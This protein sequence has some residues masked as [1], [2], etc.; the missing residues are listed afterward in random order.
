MRHTPL[1]GKGDV[2]KNSM[3]LK[4]VSAAILSALTLSAAAAAGAGK[5]PSTPSAASAQFLVQAS[6]AAVARKDVASVG[7]S[8]LQ[9]LGIV[10]AVAAR[11]NPWQVDRL[12]ALPGV[13]VFQDRALGMR[14]GLL[15]SLTSTLSSVT[16]T[17]SSTVTNVVSTTVVTANKV[18]LVSAVTTPVVAATSGSSTPQDGTGENTPTLLYQT[19]YPMLVGADTLQ[20]AGITGRRVTIAVLDSGLWQSV[21]QNYGGR[22]LA[23][24]DVT[25]GGSGPVTGDAYGHGTHITSIAA[26][27]AVNLSGNYLSI[28]PQ[29][30]LVVVRA[31]NGEGAGRYID[32]ISGLNWI[33]ANRAKYNIRVLNLSFGAPPESNYWND[34]LNQAVMAAWQAGIVVVVA[35]GNEGPAPMTIDVPGNVPY[36]ITTGALTDNYTP[37]NPADDRLA[38]FS[39]AGPT[40]E[41]FVK[42]EV[43]S[44][45][46]HMVASMSSQSYLANIDPGSMAATA[47]MFTMSGTSMAAAVTTCVVALML[48]SD[49]ALAPDDV[50][51][52]L[53]AS[54]R[55]A[56]TSAGTLAYSVFQQGAG[57][58][59]A[60]SAV[61]SSATGCANRGL[62]IA[63]DLAGTHHFGGPANQDAQGHFYVMNMAGSAWGGSQ[64]NDG[65]SWSTAFNSSQG[66]SWS[67][68]YTWSQTYS[69]NQAYAWSSGYLWSKGTTWSQGY[70]WSKSAPWW[71]SSTSPSS[72]TSP[73]SIE[74]WVPNQ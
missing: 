46:G 50:K 28:A 21:D 59:N 55:P 66:Y 7:G 49:P 23:S 16:S 56:V 53:L 68:G 12:R 71:G 58:I 26:G 11:L 35:A 40:Y 48:Q 52:R 4:L 14:G 61:N 47:D 45:G 1:S 32:V 67:E 5:T 36:V 33:V 6:S 20:Q 9:S 8:A 30:N 60:V 37:Y 25:N 19:N 29:A 64:P 63:A 39:S 2:R 41:G 22:V 42:P 73:A 34:P 65:Y 3:K 70:L 74:S 43:I 13:H 69:W 57:L 54:A 31:F 51:C 15:S 72:H 17:V 10:N 24:I 27:G 62:N 38:S 44:P 18:P